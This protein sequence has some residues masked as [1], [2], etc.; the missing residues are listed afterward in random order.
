MTSPE[1]PHQ[2]QRLPMTDFTAVYRC[3][4]CGHA[5]QVSVSA[6]LSRTLDDLDIAFQQEYGGTVIE[7]DAPV[8]PERSFGYPGDYRDPEY[9]GTVAQF[10]DI[11]LPA[12]VKALEKS[13][14]EAFADLLPP[15]AKFEW[16]TRGG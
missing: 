2:W 11:V 1:C 9:D 12:R 4:D 5:M 10:R 7:P 6:M 13:L 15:G 3:K 14:N 8:M 16:V